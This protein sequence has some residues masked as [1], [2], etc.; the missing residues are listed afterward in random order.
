MVDGGASAASLVSLVVSLVGRFDLGCGWKALCASG[1]SGSN[2]KR[3]T[4]AFLQIPSRWVLA[5]LRPAS[6]TVCIRFCLH[7]VFCQHITP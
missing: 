3:R 2:R 4:A 1:C 7:F 6:L 5:L